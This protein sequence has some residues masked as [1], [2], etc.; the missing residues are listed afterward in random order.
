MNKSAKIFLGVFL[1]CYL[2]GGVV[3]NFLLGPPAMSPEYMADYKSDHDRYLR[4]V[5]N[6]D[7]KLWKE[8]PELNPPSASLKA[9]LDFLNDYENR[10]AFRDEMTRRV[11]YEALF[12][13]FNVL[14]LIGLVY[15][16]ARK[17]ILGLLDRWIDTARTRIERA[18]KAHKAAAA[19]RLELEQKL[20]HLRDEE[21][22]LEEETNQRIAREQSIVSDS[23]EQGL[24]L[25]EQE[26]ADRKRHERD[27]A[28][29][30]LKRDL[31]ESSMNLFI[32]EYRDGQSI[33][34]ETKII[35]HFVDELKESQ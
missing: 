19:R 10:D 11:R 21:M 22:R 29:K 3:I 20:A 7:Y 16:F 35:D 32:R 18:E 1:A 5:K 15:Y 30:K 23:T 4:V 31:V 24:Q 14:M 2:V 8:R 25:L 12:D 9:D 26:T 33:N 34:S 6:D 28:A 17:P 27:M 13:V